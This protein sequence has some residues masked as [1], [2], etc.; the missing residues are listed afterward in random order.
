LHANAE[1]YAPKIEIREFRKV[2]RSNFAQQHAHYVTGY[3]EEPKNYYWSTILYN[4]LHINAKIAAG[5]MITP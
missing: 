3:Y 5:D 4:Y 1:R 2:K